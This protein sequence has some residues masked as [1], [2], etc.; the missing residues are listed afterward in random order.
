MGLHFCAGHGPGGYH[1]KDEDLLELPAD[2]KPLVARLRLE[3]ASEGAEV[4]RWRAPSWIIHR[5]QR[6][7]DME[8][9]IHPESPGKRFNQLPSMGTP[10]FDTIIF[11]VKSQCDRDERL[12]ASTCMAGINSSGD[13]RVRSIRELQ[14]RMKR[15][16]GALR[17]VMLAARS[18]SAMG[19]RAARWVC[20]R[21]RL[22]LARVLG[23][24]ERGPA[25]GWSIWTSTG[26]FC[27]L[28]TPAAGC[29]TPPGSCAGL[30]AALIWPTAFK[31]RMPRIRKSL[32]V[33]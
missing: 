12:H 33:D 15:S 25:G 27:D 10:I 6:D 22:R 28:P 1:A 3:P 24:V 19:R 30:R 29:Q 5:S 13:V 17:A 31:P 32:L 21:F 16:R 7:V 9:A 11:Y 4:Q 18:A 26:V 14:D 8:N 2:H 23:C 20:K